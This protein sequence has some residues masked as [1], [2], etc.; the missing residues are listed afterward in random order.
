[1]LRPKSILLFAA[2]LFTSFIHVSAKSNT[3]T[4]KKDIIIDTVYSYPV[5]V[6]FQSVCCGVPSDVPLQK[7]VKS[8]KTKYKIAIIDA[9]HIGPLGREGEY[10]LAFPLNEMTDPQKKA[11]IKT[12]KSA[13]KKMT[14]KGKANLQLIA[15]YDPKSLPS[16]VQFD[17]VGF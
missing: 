17:P 9:V 5:A 12:L 10:D 16:R 15:S 4:V 2:F 14:N 1:M 7:A 13:V 11:F 8:F 3:K 6:K